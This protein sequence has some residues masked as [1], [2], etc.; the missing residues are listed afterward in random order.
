MLSQEYT[1]IRPASMSSA[2]A[3]MSSMRSTSSA[4]P[5]AVGN[6]ITGRPKWPH[7]TTV[8]SLSSRDEYQRSRIFMRAE[9]G[10]SGVEQALLAREQPVEAVTEM[11]A[12]PRPCVTVEGFHHFDLRRHPTEHVDH[13]EVALGRRLERAVAEK[14]LFH[15][16]LRLRADG[17]DEAHHGV[18]RGAALVLAAHH[19][20]E[21]RSRLQQQAAVETRRSPCRRQCRDGPEARPGAEPAG[22]VRA[23]GKPLLEERHKLG[24][25]EAAVRGTGAVLTQPLAGMGERN[26]AAGH[27]AL[28]HEVVENR[29]ERRVLE[30]VTTVVHHEQGEAI[31][32]A[33]PRR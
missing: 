12:P 6:T 9:S 1:L 27:C 4:S 5:P 8:T 17:V 7:R 25:E 3:S 15:R 18:E 32:A 28:V 22:R 26:H 23:Q 30:V 31:L 11:V 16:Q 10:A 20:V 21:E 29:P 33:H 24:G 2:S 13:G 14:D 19:G